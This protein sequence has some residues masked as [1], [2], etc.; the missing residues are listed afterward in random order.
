MAS[1]WD[2]VVAEKAAPVE[3]AA[4]AQGKRHKQDTAAD[5]ADLFAMDW[6]PDG[7][8]QHKGKKA[9]GKA[10]GKGGKA[11]AEAAPEEAEFMEDEDLSQLFQ[12]AV[13]RKQK[14]IKQKPPIGIRDEPSWLTD[15][16]AG[17]RKKMPDEDE[18]P[19][20]STPS[21]A[22]EYILA[23]CF[24]NP[25]T[26]KDSCLANIKGSEA[27]QSF[28]ADFAVDIIGAVKAVS[29]LLLFGPSGTGKTASVLALA[30]EFE[31]A[32]FQITAADLPN[33]AKGCARIDAV[34]SLAARKQPTFIIVDEA[35]TLLAA[36]AGQ[37][38]GHFAA[39]WQR[40]QEGLLVV[41]TTNAPWKIAPKLLH[42]RF[43][44][45]IHMPTPP[46]RHRLAL[47]QELVSLEESEPTLDDDDWIQIIKATNGR[48]AVNL[49]R[50]V[51]TAAANAQGV[52]LPISHEDFAFA[53]DREPSDYDEVVVK[54]NF[55]FDKKFGWRCT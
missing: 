6:A 33:G 15:A 4:S 8:M 37:R 7:A 52:G 42:G 43:E 17:L 20:D 14:T 41:G 51:S 23:H 46:P 11:K 28:A 16:E 10:V 32:V 45:K 40:F 48:S 29:G 9:L 54:E 44:R 30:N 24:M 18:Q 34:F 25:E 22:E 1:I 50:L 38:V 55:K 53:L 31:A 27:V 39:R 47:M 36:T 19:M 49:Q 13:E 3:P 26:Y 2:D 5:D 35:D 12:S 21:E